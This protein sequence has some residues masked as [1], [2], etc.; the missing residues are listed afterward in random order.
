MRATSLFDL[1]HRH[2]EASGVMW[3]VD[4]A[5]PPRSRQREVLDEVRV[6]RSLSDEE[7][8]ALS[9]RMTAVEYLADQVILGLASIPITCW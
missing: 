9:Q 4:L 2:L 8:D 5:L 3:N 7:R 6:F 1:A